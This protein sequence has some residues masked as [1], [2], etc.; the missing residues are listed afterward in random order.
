MRQWDFS[1]KGSEK[2]DLRA[3]EILKGDLLIINFH[4][5][6]A[7]SVSYPNETQNN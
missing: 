4:T 7:N 3:I 1:D 6:N 5:R 2:E